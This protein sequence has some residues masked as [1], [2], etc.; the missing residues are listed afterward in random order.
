M[1]LLKDDLKKLYFHFLIPSLGS[2]MVMSIYTLTD[3]IVIGMIIQVI[4]GITHFFSRKNELKF[5]RPKH[6]FWSIGQIISNGV[7]SFFN[8]FANGFIVLLF[9]I[10][11]LKYCGE[12]ALSVY[13]VISNCVILFNSLFTGVG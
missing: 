10:Q 8:E 13:S 5:I 12:S 4:T 2:A 7:P 1:D 11:I 6:V 3:A 9:N